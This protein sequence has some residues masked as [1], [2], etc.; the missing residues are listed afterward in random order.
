MEIKN[1]NNNEHNFLKLDIEA[2]VYTVNIQKNIFT[3]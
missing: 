1:K 2:K 3:Y